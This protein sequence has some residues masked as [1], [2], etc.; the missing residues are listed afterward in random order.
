[1]M[2]I[3]WPLAT[4]SPTVT[5]SSDTTPSA[6]ATIGFSI[7][8][9]STTQ[10]T[11]PASTA[12]PSATSTSQHRSLH[13]AHDRVG[14]RAGEALRTL[15]V[16]PSGLGPG[17]VGLLK[18]HLVQP[19]VELD[20]QDPAPRAGAV[21]R[22]RGSPDDPL[23]V[24]LLRAPGE[25][26]RLHDPGTRLATSEAGALEQRAVERDE[27]RRAL[28]D[29]LLERAQ[30]PASRV[31]AIDVVD[32]QLRDERVV[33]ARHLVARA[34]ARVDAYADSR[35]LT[36][37]GDPA[38]ARQE[39]FRRILGVDPALDRMAAEHDVLLRDGQPLPGGDE[40][41]LP[42]EV[43]PRDHL[44]DRVLHLDPGVHLEEVVRAVGGEEPLHGAG[45]A[46]AD[47]RGR[48]DGDAPDALAQRL[49]DSRRRRLLDELLVASLDGAVAL[50]EVDDVAVS[51]GEH[52]DLDVPRIL[53]V[54]LDVHGR[55]GEVRLALA[56]RRLERPLD[57]LRRPGDL[58][59][60]APAAGGRLDRDREADLVL[61]P[62]A[63]PRRSLPARSRRARSG[64]P[65]RAS[66]R[67]PRSSSPWP[68]SRQ[69]AGRS[70]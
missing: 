55:V 27:R 35:R 26:L 70:R 5:P 54:A 21:R 46:I 33:E 4:C 32:D 61:R 63:R 15:P 2:Q 34:D 44:R 66:A 59:T 17:R 14:A 6:W 68:R 1:M 22:G 65:P 30:H 37:R 19:S 42:H 60:L 64:L 7:F 24:E 36:V 52:L 16:P 23:L 31:V 47:R 49:V 12:S 10:I 9:A 39:A 69:A 56:P 51:V 40:D 3:T 25:R 50:A 28:D 20:G 18:A 8:I 58:E 62:R 67:E 41:L 53:E 57:L 29:V 38:R 11:R 48:V 13:R 45:R 43:E